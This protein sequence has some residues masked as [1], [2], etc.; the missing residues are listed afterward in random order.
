[1]RMPS[2]IVAL[3][4]LSGPAAAQTPIEIDRTL[5]KVYGTAVMSSDVRQAKML[6]LLTPAPENDG[7]V[8]TALENRLLILHEAARSGLEDPT[9]A[10][11]ADRKRAWLSSW[12]PGTD[13][14]KLLERGGMSD[15]ALDGWFRDD[16]RIDAYL[17][18]RFSQPDQ[19]RDERVAEWLRDLRHRA[20]LPIK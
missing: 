1:M 7:A 19:K 13:M 12:P 14:P 10:R 11:I 2:L 8:Q 20:N 18:S 15:R 17:Q 3:L 9:P 5:Q 4:L 16:L 6:R